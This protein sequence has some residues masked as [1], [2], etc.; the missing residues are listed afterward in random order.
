MS[1]DHEHGSAP[2]GSIGAQ[3]QGRLLL[4]LGLTLGYVVIEVLGGVYTGSLALIADA[5]HMFTDGLGLA[6]A[7]AA[8]RFAQRPATPQ[9]TYGFYRAE[10]LAALANGIVLFGVAAYILF[11]AW[12]RFQEP[13]MVDAV[14]MLLVAC[15]G[16]V[17]TLTGVML[18]RAG[19]EQS[20]NVKGA[21]LEV[22]SDMVGAIGTIMAALVLLLTGWA[23]ADPLVSVGIGLFIIPRAWGLLK[24]VIDVLL[25][26]APAGLR[27][28]ELERTIQAVPGVVA[29]HDL[30]VWTITSGFVAMSGH[31]ET[32]DRRP[33]D[34]M[35]DIQVQLR[36][37]FGI[38][39][40]T[41]QVEP[42]D[43]AGDGACCT[44]DP[45]CLVV[46][47][48]AGAQLGMGRR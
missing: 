37:T 17:V 45:R 24:S 8:I 31:V 15:G 41:L 4:M 18:L 43:H 22:L 5:G 44:V 39:H 33:S 26:A 6:M 36:E 11:E 1:T 35:H 38:Q 3:H 48:R 19:A 20:L 25:E 2:V 32:R 16:L 42:A 10:I 34:V 27:V 28:E 40:A 9:K 30:H 23:Y 12:R 47:G 13:R 21:F 29:A 46:G 7:L 14:P